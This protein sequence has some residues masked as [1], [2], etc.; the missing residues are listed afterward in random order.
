LR[1]VFAG[2][3][4]VAVTSLRAL[5]ASRHTVAAVVTR[6]DAPTGRGRKVEPSPVAALAREHG[7]EVLTPG[8]PREPQFLDRLRQIAPDCC[9]VTAYGALLPQAALDIPR[10]GWVNLH[11]SLLPAWR[12]AAPVQHAV[13]HGDDISGAT[14]FRIVQELDAGPV[15]GVVTEPI[16]PDDTSG[17]LLG[18]LA[19]SGAGLLVATLDAIEDGAIR[20]EPQPAEGV[21]FAPKLNPAD[22]RVDWKLPAH[23]ID[24]AIRACTPDPGAWTEFEQARIRIFPLT[25]L[26]PSSDLPPLAPG[27]LHVS[28]GAV[29]AGTGSRPVLLADVQPPGKRRMPAADW[30][31]GLRGSGDGAASLGFT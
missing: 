22:A 17:D 11:F 21:S 28:R 29:H 20:A 1:L 9:P 7:L 3:P 6:P 23:L 5:L 30:A 25:S 10:F 14:T 31:R 16:R 2:T 12:G 15:F 4:A 19:E 26:A 24:R 8:R 18:R 13:L 27:E